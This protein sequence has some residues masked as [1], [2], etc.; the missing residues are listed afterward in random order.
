MNAI[1]TLYDGHQ[2][3]S[4][5][6]A[7]WA[8]FFNEL[9]VKYE[10]E[11]EAFICADGSQYTP[12]FFLPD[13]FLRDKDSK[14]VYVEIK[15]DIFDSREYAEYLLRIA[16]ALDG[17]NFVLLSG[18]PLHLVRYAYDKHYYAENKSEQIQPWWDNEMVLMFCEKCNIL[19][20]EFNEGN[21]F[22]CPVCGNDTWDHP[23]R[24]AALVARK[25]R[26]VFN[27]KK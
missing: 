27:N 24:K 9:E 8:V 11:P 5:L 16:S 12:D 22:N 23:I 19:K 25:Y 1:P 17:S 15:P 21:Y 14:G 7:R 10:Y 20:V 13:T 4:K 26:F 3:R 2:F 18:D 6:E